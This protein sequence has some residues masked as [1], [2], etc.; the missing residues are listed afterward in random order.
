MK[1]RLRKGT[2]KDLNVY[3]VGFTSGSGAGLLGYATFPWFYSSAS[4]D[5][6]VVVLFKS[7]PGGAETNYNMGRTLTHEVGHWLGLYHSESL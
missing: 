2:A 3:T 5:D 7:L 6:G 1:R 4:W